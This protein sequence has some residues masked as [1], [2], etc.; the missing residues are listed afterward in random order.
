VR[1]TLGDGGDGTWSAPVQLPDSGSWRI[2]PTLDGRGAV[3]PAVV[4]VGDAPVPGAPPR[5]VLVTA[6]LSARS[7]LRCRAHLQGAL[8]AI[9]RL[10][11][12]GG[13]PDGHKVVLEVHDDGGDSERA[14]ALARV[15]RARGA[16]ALL[17]PCGDGA[18]GALRGAGDLPTI[19]ADPLVPTEGG[20]RAWRTAGDPRAE[21]L[22]V[23][24][25][26]GGQP[27]ASAVD[28]PSTVAAIGVPDDD[29]AHA[30]AAARV[31]GL[32]EALRPAG[33]RVRGVP[34][35]ALDSP[36]TLRRVLD[37]D[38]YRA[39]FV[40]GDPARVSRALRAYGHREGA[41]ALNTTNRIIAASPL[42]D[43]RFQRAAGPLGAIGAISSPSEVL[44]DSRDAL[45]YA[46]GM[47]AFF[48]GDQPSLEGLRGYVAG[49][50]LGY[51]LRHGPDA[52]SIAARLRR[53]P[54]FTDALVAPWRSDAPRAGAPLFVF[55][56][57]R[58]LT[59]NL[60]PVGQGGQ[61]HEG[62]FFPD[63]AWERTS[64]RPYG[65][66]SVGG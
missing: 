4:A 27:P 56:A 13:T 34:A 7:A 35:A 47:R 18:A 57:P 11:A 9:G 14:E 32:R 22:A 65:L 61:E 8:L 59:A 21:G 42:L 26:L 10:N 17:T 5:P 51:G 38:Q 24:R 63:G 37:P 58:F 23:G 40:D 44:P 54:P 62:T 45:S 33:V 1:V 43:E 46:A 3:A 52:D 20:R 12:Q 36:A 60:L 25:Y 30:T 2:A 49:L 29:P 16:I 15:W 31:A 55:L 53:P 48:R 39:T 28:P 41:G 19:V 64:T 6:D 50:A 66:A